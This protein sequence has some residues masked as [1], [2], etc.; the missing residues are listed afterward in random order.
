VRPPSA[1]VIP[2]FIKDAYRAA[3]FGRPGPAFVDLPANLILGKY[4]V[5]RQ[6]L[7]PLSEVPT[8]VPPE[9]KLRDV[10]NAL[11]NA[12][13]PLVVLGKGAAYARAEGPIRALIE[14]YDFLA[15]PGGVCFSLIYD[16][17]YPHT[18]CT[19]ADGQ[20]HRCRFE[21]LQLFGCTLYRFQGSRRRSRTRRSL[22]LDSCLRS[23]TQMERHRWTSA[24]MSW[25]RMAETQPSVF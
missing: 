2:K 8:S 18:F 4:E 25:E 22:E 10:V 12:K 13:A 9:N 24:P 20:G 7:L 21:S 6:K 15:R 11:K 3:Y 23:T 1:D 14:R 16:L 17:Q 5:G 19:Y